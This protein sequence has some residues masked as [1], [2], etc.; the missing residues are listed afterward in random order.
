VTLR[1][2][3][4]GAAGHVTETIIHGGAIAGASSATMR[5]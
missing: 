2:G 3:A 5:G 1:T 4:R